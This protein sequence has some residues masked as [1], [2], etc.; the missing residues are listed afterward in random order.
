MTDFNTIYCYFGKGLLFGPPCIIH[1][2]E[3][4]CCNFILRLSVHVLKDIS[5]ICSSPSLSNRRLSAASWTDRNSITRRPPLRTNRH[6][7][8]VVNRDSLAINTACYVK[9]FKNN[10][11]RVYYY[12]IV[13]LMQ[14]CFW[15]LKFSNETWKYG[16][17]PEVWKLVIRMK[18]EKKR[19]MKPDD[20]IIGPNDK[21]SIR[22]ICQTELQ[23]EK[24]SEF[25]T[26]LGEK[27]VF[28]AE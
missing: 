8:Y 4:H 7:S 9:S 13:L 27:I 23:T 5:V 6:Y 25:G 24:L 18:D 15:T 12:Y 19:N 11:T 26:F 28:F 16:V 10:K 22:K 20:Y 14:C 1:V 17:P 3:M 21:S 2:H